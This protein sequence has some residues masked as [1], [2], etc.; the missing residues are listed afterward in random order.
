MW[1]ASA[2]AAL[3]SALAIEPSDD[4]DARIL[5]VLGRVYLSWGRQGE[6]RLAFQRII[7]GFP[8]SPVADNSTDTANVH[9]MSANVTTRYAT[10]RIRRGKMRCGIMKK[11]RRRFACSPDKGL[12]DMSIV[13]SLFLK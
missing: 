12:P 5:F 9:K 6:A 2:Q 13:P 4:D 10:E 3:K 1:K 11:R 8:E 7:A